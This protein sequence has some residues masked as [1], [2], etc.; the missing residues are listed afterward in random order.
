MIFIPPVG[1]RHFN[2]L[3]VVL[4]HAQSGLP[5]PDFPVGFGNPTGAFAEY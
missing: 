4:K 5:N 3:S 2:S 1:Y